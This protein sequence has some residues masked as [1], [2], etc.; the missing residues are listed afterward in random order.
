[1][2]KKALITSFIVLNLYAILCGGLYFFQENLLFHPQQLPQE[3]A[4]NF[5]HQ[6]SEVFL[7][8]SDGARLHGLHFRIENP[9]GVILYYHGNA[10]SL[11]G[12]GEVVQYFIKKDFS[13]IAMDYRQ[14]GKSSG[15]WS[16]ENLYNDSLLWYAFTK[17]EYPE[18]PLIVYG[19][20]LG[21]TFATYVASQKPVHHLMLEAPFYSIAEV[22]QAKFP[23]LP[24]SSL[25]KYTFPTY[26]FIPDLKTGL[27]SL[28]HGTE[29]RVIN[30]KHGKKLYQD[31]KVADKI[32]ITI[33]DGGHHNLIDFEQY[34]KAMV[35]RLML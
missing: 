25:L 8:A 1:M 3:Y 19:R 26:E 7:E 17:K 5:E 14:Y 23:I 30:Y 34:D 13:V 2:I 21:T 12:W 22:A 31:L 24:T 6:P 32:F 29:D 20:S 27:V 9:K 10:G 11:A 28:F 4:F 35:K 15:M 16:Q 33:P 18:T